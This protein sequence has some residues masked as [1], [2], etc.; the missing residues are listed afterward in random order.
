[1]PRVYQKHRMAKISKNTLVLP[2]VKKAFYFAAQKHNRQYRKGTKVPYFA[3]S[4]LV[5]LGVSKYS[6]EP[7]TI[8]AAVL[9][10]VL[11]DCAVTPKQLS[12]LFGKKVARIVVELSAS[13]ALINKRT[14]WK[15]K[16]QAYLRKIKRASRETLVIIAIDKITNMQS[17]FEAAVSM[18]KR[19]LNSLFGGTSS[20][21]F[22]YYDEIYKILHSKLKKHPVTDLYKKM[23]LL[24][25]ASLDSLT[26]GILPSNLSTD[27]VQG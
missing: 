21:Y 3:H 24:Y 15:T 19:R 26:Q 10:D 1:M 22:W 9:H 17:Y 4:A 20:E 2:L 11:E 8:A 16:K 5:A 7:E 6:S 18:E 12:K 25:R 13:S 27:V 14:V 23:F